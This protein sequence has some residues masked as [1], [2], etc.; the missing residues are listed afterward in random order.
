[1]RLMGLMSGTSV[2]SIDCAVADLWLGD[3]D[4]IGA[5]VV[6]FHEHSMSATLKS[7]IF[8][9]FADDEHSLSL[10]CSL[11]FE[12]GNAFAD[13]AL[14]AL[15][16]ANIPAESISAIASHGQTLYHIAPHMANEL[17][18]GSTLQVGEAS[19]IAERT[20][21]PVISDFRVADMA[22]GGNGA[23]LVPFADFHLFSQAGK[24]IV[25]QNIGG[26]AN[27][28]LLPASGKLDDVIAFDTGPGN[29]LVDALVQRLFAPLTFDEN[30]AIASGGRICAELLERWMAMPYIKAPPP[31]STGRE[32]FG[33]QFADAVIAENREVP[34]ADLVATATAFTSKSIVQNLVQHVF[35]RWPSDRLLVAGGGA[36]NTFLVKL[37]R[38]YAGAAGHDLAVGTLEEIG[39]SSKARECLAFAL[40]GYSRILGIPANVPSATGAAHPC[41]LGKITEPYHGKRLFICKQGGYEGRQ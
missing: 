13:A 7:R 12:I 24:S 22:A 30:G 19:V 18:V 39:F 8:E 4:R 2:D 3:N 31:K 23:P 1:M 14:T 21:L 17:R 26:I 35:P 32:L 40:L 36:Q 16:R 37:I 29:M 15:E 28:T 33:V 38:E 25:L 10:G 27:C 5:K 41:L 6:A 9:S 20:G 11:N 34:A